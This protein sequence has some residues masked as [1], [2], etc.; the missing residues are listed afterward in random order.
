MTTPN[1]APLLRRV[2]LPVIATLIIG[3]LG[4]APAS[5]AVAYS[6]STPIV[7]QNVSIQDI[8]ANRG[9]ICHSTFTHVIKNFSGV[10][11]TRNYMVAAQKCGLK[12][13]A[14]FS[15][16]VSAGG[17]VYP[18]RVRTWVNLVKNHPAL[19]GYLSA[20]EPSR[21]HVSPAEIR[22]LYAAYKAADPNHPVMV[23][24]GDVPH[25]G[26]RTNPYSTRMADVVMVNWYPV[27]TAS[28]G[29]SRTG[30]SYVA[31]GPKHFRRIRKL[32]AATTPGTPIWLMVGT[33]RYL[34]PAAHKKQRPTQALLHRQVRDGFA[35]L[36]ADGMAFHTWSNSSYS[37]DNRRDGTMINWMRDLGARI[38]S[39][40]FQ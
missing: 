28:G 23:L 6:S 9:R 37:I 3:A 1:R 24:F 22:R 39:Q 18:S 7:L 4:A 40:T 17:T 11:N 26:T 10:N 19:W 14:Y 16:A 33:H 38:Q 27:E 2:W 30:T 13:I 21:T 32:V 5:A 25:F 35:S 36:G 29:R 31:T 15:A 8:N 12:V 34:A 20:K